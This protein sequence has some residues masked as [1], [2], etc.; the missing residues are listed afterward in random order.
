M[1]SSNRLFCPLIF[2]LLAFAG[3]S[4]TPDGE[5]P[6]NASA[7]VHRLKVVASFL[8]IYAHTS[9]VAG[10][11]ADVTM[12]LQSDSGPHDYQLA[13]D[14]MKR[15]ADADLFVVNGGGIEAW[16]DDLVQAVGSPR[17]KVVDTG[18][19]IVPSD[20]PEEITLGQSGQKHRHE[21]VHESEEGINPHYWLDP[22]HA[23]SQ[24]EVIRDALISADPNQGGSYQANAAAYIL[25]L[26]AL[27]AA[28]QTALDTLPGKNLVTFHDAFPYFARRY[29][30]NYV[31]F[32][33][34]FP[35][36]DPSPRQLKA[37]VD[38]IRRNQVKVLFAETGY[39]PAIL[40]TLAA[41][42]GARVAELDTLEVGEPVPDAYLV[43]M[44]NNLR[45]LQQAAP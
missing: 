22:V 26:Q 17:L 30:L 34:A 31:G 21:H 33:E 27:H 15:I 37:L 32:I 8:P 10:G 39:A 1:D 16:L 45:A 29:G 28:F 24:V 41:E 35:E 11:S 13:P 2:S 20:V 4:P 25:E 3:C 42:T 44:R 14:D 6:V 23:I 38:A 7:P 18:V 5:T 19:G 40:R 36:K 12:L 9:R 43:R